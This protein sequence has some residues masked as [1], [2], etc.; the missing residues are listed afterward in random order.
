MLKI[1]AQEYIDIGASIN[2]ASSIL[3]LAEMSDGEDRKLTSDELKDLKNLLRDLA[4]KCEAIGLRVTQG[5][6]E[7]MIGDPPRTSR[8]LN[9]ILYA[10]NLE[11]QDKLFFFVPSERAKYY[12]R[13]SEI[14]PVAVAQFPNAIREIGRAGNCFAFGEYAASVFHCMRAMESALNALYKCLGILSPTERNWGAILREIR[15]EIMR[16]GSSWSEQQKFHDLSSTLAAVKDGWRNR[17]MHVDAVYYEDDAARI[18]QA[19]VNFIEKIA[20]E[21]DEDG[22]P[23]A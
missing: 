15:E 9:T 16:R 8:E 6:A 14:S 17:T 23:L 20:S 3:G 2:E 4:G 1:Y 19:V 5:L 11:I 10:L 12:D 18:Y 21:M 13:V 7:G 22:L